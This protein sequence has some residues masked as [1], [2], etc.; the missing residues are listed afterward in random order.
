MCA[1]PWKRF[2][3][4][5]QRRLAAGVALAAYLVTILGLPVPALR[6]KD[7]SQP[8]PCQHH[9]CGCRTAVDCWSSCCC[10]SAAEK[11]LWAC[12]NG[13]EPPTPQGWCS[14]R[15]R[16]RHDDKHSCCEKKT[17]TA[18]RTSRSTEADTSGKTTSTWTIGMSPMRCQG[19]NTLWLSSGVVFPPPAQFSWQANLVPVDWLRTSEKLFNGL[20][21]IPPDPPPRLHV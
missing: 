15:L 16:D 19:A 1:R 6:A 3:R 14:T 17:K 5:Q 8:F 7:P 4:S 20:P 9:A 11:Q 10:Y 18:V 21:S 13:V 2:W 12:N